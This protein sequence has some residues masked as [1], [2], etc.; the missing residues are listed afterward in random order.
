MKIY[1]IDGIISDL[2]RTLTRK[3]FIHSLNVMD[4]AENLA[5]EQGYDLEKAKLAGLLHDCARDIKQ[6]E[7]IAICEKRGIGLNYVELAQ[8]YLLHGAAGMILAEE[9][10]GIKDRE[11]L[12][13][14]RYHTTGRENMTLCEKIIFTADYIEPGREQPGIGTIREMAPMDL[15]SACLEILGNIIVFVVGKNLMLHGDTVRARNFLLL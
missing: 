6:G 10:Y 11:I 5:K 15:D 8:P 3:R 2:R 9:K 7:L 1:D 4:T 12:N 13:A 14:I